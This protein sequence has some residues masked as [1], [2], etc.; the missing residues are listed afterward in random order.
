MRNLVLFHKFD[1]LQLE[2]IQDHLS[3]LHFEKVEDH[4][5]IAPIRRETKE[6][7]HPDQLIVDIHEKCIQIVGDVA[8]HRGKGSVTDPRH[9]LLGE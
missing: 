8:S 7:Y 5:F 2:E 6:G 9:P 3:L 1:N 4:S